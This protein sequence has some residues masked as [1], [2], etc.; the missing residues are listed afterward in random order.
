MDLEE[1]FFN[2]TDYELEKKKLG[3]GAFG[4][5]Y[6]AKNLIDNKQYAAKLIRCSEGMSGHQQML[7]LLEW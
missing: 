7:F 1:V 4:T 2:T 3:E 6:V 5:V